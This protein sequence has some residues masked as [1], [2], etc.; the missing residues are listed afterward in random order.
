MW[1]MSTTY[2]ETVLIV[3]GVWEGFFPIFKLAIAI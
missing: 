3:G 1:L 2:I